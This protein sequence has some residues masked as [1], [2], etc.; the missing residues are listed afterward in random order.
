MFDV[1]RSMF[2]VQ[3][4]VFKLIRSQIQNR[5]KQLNPEYPT[6]SGSQHNPGRQRFTED[7]PLL[8]TGHR[9]HSG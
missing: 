3:I 4:P 1:G 5:T 6:M 9:N 2:E 7:G 8:L